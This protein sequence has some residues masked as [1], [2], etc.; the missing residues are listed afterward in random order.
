M[1]AKK[2]AKLQILSKVAPTWYTKTYTHRTSYRIMI[3]TQTAKRTSIGCAYS[4]GNCMTTVTYGTWLLSK[5]TSNTQGEEDIQWTNP[6]LAF[7]RTSSAQ[8]SGCREPEV[9]MKRD[10]ISVPSWVSQPR[11][12]VVS[13]TRTRTRNVSYV[14][15]TSQ[16]RMWLYSVCKKK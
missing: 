5:K 1:P 10:N 14:H 15:Q 7:D 3:A 6:L 8:K 11:A 16:G 13:T 9:I 4:G 2:H 12:T